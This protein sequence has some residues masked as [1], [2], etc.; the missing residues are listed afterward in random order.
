MGKSYFCTKKYIKGKKENTRYV[1]GKV[2]AIGNKKNM[3]NRTVYYSEVELENDNQVLRLK[4][5][6]WE[7]IHSKL[8]KLEEEYKYVCRGE[9]K[10]YSIYS[11]YCFLCIDV[12]FFIPVFIFA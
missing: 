1:E 3:K 4:G 9:D 11:L 8:Y 10:I 6:E 7:T 12:L 2:I 5:E